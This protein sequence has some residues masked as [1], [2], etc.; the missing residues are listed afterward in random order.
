MI[1]YLILL[2]LCPWIAYL[3][4]IQSGQ[5]CLRTYVP[6]KNKA[7]LSNVQL[8]MAAIPGLSYPGAISCSKS[9][10]CV[11]KVHHCQGLWD[12]WCK[13]PDAMCMHQPVT[14]T[15]LEQLRWQLGSVVGSLGDYQGGE[16]A[17]V[18][19]RA[20]EG[21]SWWQ[22]CA[23]ES[24][25][26]PFPSPTCP[27]RLLGLI[28]AMEG[29]IGGQAAYGSESVT[30]FYLPHLGYLV[31]LPL[32][33]KHIPLTLLYCIGQYGLGLGQK[34]LKRNGKEM[35][36]FYAIFV[37]VHFISISKPVRLVSW[38]CIP[39]ETKQCRRNYRHYQPW[40]Y[41]LLTHWW[42]WCGKVVH[43]DGCGWEYGWGQ[44]GQRLP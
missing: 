16:S 25:P 27:L 43:W 2:W 36:T 23:L 29:P 4:E 41:P 15:T 1:D 30:Y 7:T 32:D 11:K 21:R 24:Y 28:Q 37:S 35:A 3:L 39:M 26:P 10:C 44:L 20:R 18:S 5:F 38:S 40:W 9:W 12:N 31:T 34:K 22:S 17:G 19:S 33:A 8:T 14:Q 6:S 13:W 42:Q